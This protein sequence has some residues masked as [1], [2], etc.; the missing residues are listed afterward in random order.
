M[1]ETATSDDDDDND[2]NHPTLHTYCT[3]MYIY[4]FE[5]SIN[6]SVAN[7]SNNLEMF[8]GITALRISGREFEIMLHTIHNW[9]LNFLYN[10]KIAIATI[11]NSYI[12]LCRTI[13]IVIWTHINPNHHLISLLFRRNNFFHLYTPRHDATQQNATRHNTSKVD[14]III[15]TTN[16]SD[17]W[18]V[19]SFLM[20]KHILSFKISY[21]VC[22]QFAF[23][24]YEII[25][26]TITANINHLR[27]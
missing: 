24:I 20:Q 26:I 25:S 6:K 1:I 13:Y 7:E 19:W 15:L 5:L 22:W 12:Q 16:E 10:S 21:H 18:L 4:M 17:E 14:A 27:Y 11:R 8:Q 3:S 9:N 2:F 23:L